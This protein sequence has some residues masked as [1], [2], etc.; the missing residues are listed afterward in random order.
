MLVLQRKQGESVIIIDTV[1]KEE[2]VVVVTDTA[3]GKARLGFTASQRYQ[4]LRKE[5][6]NIEPKQLQNDEGNK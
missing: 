6:M 3:N 1:T 5:L 2:I 4:I